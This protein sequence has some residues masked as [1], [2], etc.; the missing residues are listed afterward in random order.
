MSFASVGIP[1]LICYFARSRFSSEATLKRVALHPSRQSV[2]RKVKPISLS[3][4]GL[5]TDFRCSTVYPPILQKVQGGTTYTS[6]EN[7]S[8]EIVQQ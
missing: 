6:E 4:T 5:V 8:A 2:G 3:G 1:Y 7:G